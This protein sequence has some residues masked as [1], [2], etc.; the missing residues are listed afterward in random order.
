MATVGR[1]YLACA[2]LKTP[3]FFLATPRKKVHG[4]IKSCVDET[5]AIIV[6]LFETITFKLCQLSG[7]VFALHRFA[8][9][10]VRRGRV[11]HQFVVGSIAYAGS[12]H[13]Y[14]AML[15]LC[16]A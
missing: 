11:Q 9:A 3:R 15:T 5:I 14:V 16:I 4:D 10:V 13:D 1:V 6:L 2:S 7:G 12:V 8:T